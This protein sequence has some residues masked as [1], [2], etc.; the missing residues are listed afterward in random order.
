MNRLAQETSPYLLQHKDNP[1]H[2]RAWGDAAL[3]EAQAADKPILLSVGYAACHWCHVMA[4]ESFENPAIAGLMNEFFVNIKVDREE[5]P[6]IDGIYQSALA[7]LGQQGG[8][9]LTMFLTPK[10]E[11][12]WGGTYFPP[13]ERWGRPGFPQVLETIAGIYRKEPDKVAKNVGALR[14]ALAELAKPKPGD[15]ISLEITD[16]IAERLL[17]EVDQRNG[18]IGGAPKFPQGS[19]FELLWRGWKRSGNEAMRDAVLLTLSRMANGGIYDHLGGGF[20][21]YAV[22]AEWLVPHFEKMLYDN[23]QLLEL[24]TLAWQETKAPLFEARVRETVGW[25]LREMRADVGRSGKRGFAASL[26]ADSEHEEGKFYVWTEAEID[27]ALGAEAALFKRHYD[28]TPTGNWEGKVILNRNAAPDEPDAATEARL[29]A[30]R[31]KLLALR[32]G[33]VRPGWDDKALADWNGLMVAALAFAATVFEEPA[34]LEAAREAFAFVRTDM[35]EGGRLRHSFRNGRLKHPATL[36]DYAANS[37]AALALHAATGEAE[38]LA[39]AEEWIAVLDRHY[40]DPASG[41][42]FFTADDTADLIQRS[43]HAQDNAVPPGNAILVGVLTRLYLITGKDDYRARAAAIVAA[44][45]GELGRNFF[46]LA[47]LINQNEFMLNPLQVVL[48]GDPSSADLGA[49]RRAVLDRSLPNL[50]L[51]QVAPGAKLP[52]HHPA[53]G[54]QSVAGKATAFVC[55]GQTCSLPITDAPGLGRALQY[56]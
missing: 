43:K 50:V 31:A 54:K 26:D 7:L 46:P 32:A 49:L 22:D 44:F 52:P 8:W 6:D 47:T 29:A 37:R 48:V 56:G 25:V 14:G 20:A 27:A 5:R 45:A 28:V 10:G 35:T 40:W 30:A 53:A 33:R 38:Y 13:A 1:V 21:R 4:Q 15:G 51:Q 16:K 11:P 2:W 23:A 12:F 34:W 55:R 42:Y 19:I 39:A 41:G 18:G 3:A 24:Y 9:P 17:Q 36:D